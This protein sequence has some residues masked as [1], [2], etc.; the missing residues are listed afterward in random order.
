M[1]L[2]HWIVGTVCALAL[3]VLATTTQAVPF[4]SSTSDFKTTAGETS[5]V[6]D[7]ASRRCWWR[8]GR[9]H[10]GAYESPR[11]HG[12][13]NGISDYYVHDPSQVPFGSQRWWDLKDAEGSTGRP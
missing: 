4:T 3:V 5:D 8:N 9:Q 10:C 6:D 1:E 12:N 11:T 2:K 13:R 7:A